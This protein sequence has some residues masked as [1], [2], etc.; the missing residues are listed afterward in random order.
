MRGARLTLAREV[1]CLPQF[2]SNLAHKNSQRM[3][4]GPDLGAVSPPCLG[5]ELRP[6]V[7]APEPSIPSGSAVLYGTKYT[8]RTG[9]DALKSG[10]K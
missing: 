7:L 2:A 6:L 10:N 8:L 9:V 1:V 3:V 4:R 5:Q